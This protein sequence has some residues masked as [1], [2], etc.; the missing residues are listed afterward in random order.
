MP[1]DTR[2]KLSALEAVFQEMGSVITAFSGGVDSTLVAV[3]AHRVLAERALAVTAVSPAL[4]ARELDDATGLAASRGFA[5]RVI[6][7]NEMDREGYTAN[8]PA[9]AIS[10]R[11]N[12]TLSSRPWPMPKAIPGSP[13]APT[14]TTGATT[15]PECRPP[16]NTGCGAL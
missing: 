10:V 11:P 1:V 15:A 13:T 4:A 2:N 9:A 8:S 3:T 14:P 6:N 5:H 7:T 16:R 12:S